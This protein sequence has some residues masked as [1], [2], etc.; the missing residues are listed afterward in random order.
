MTSPL[1][2]H[3]L[4]G[5]PASG[6]STFA[7]Q[8]NQQI[9]DSVVVSTDTIRERLFGDATIQED[10]NRVEEMVIEHIRLAISYRQIVI[11]DA[12]NVSLSWRSSF[13][14]KVS[15]LNCEWIAWW[16]KTPPNVC[17]NWNKYRYRRV[18]NQVIDTYY[19]YLLESPPS[20]DEGFVA[21]KEIHL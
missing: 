4:I 7:H 17:K 13:L 19:Q 6:K 9:P 2:C 5:L 18:P 11:Y 21:L 15:D 14:D 3:F 12:T 8:L 1:L 20:I 10:W 16:I